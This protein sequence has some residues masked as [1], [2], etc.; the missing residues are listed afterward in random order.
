MD[1]TKGGRGGEGEACVEGRMGS[2][3]NGLVSS[4]PLD[5]LLS[6]RRYVGGWMM[7]DLMVALL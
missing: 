1:Q 6:G 5:Y 4:S 2:K 7:K 3:L